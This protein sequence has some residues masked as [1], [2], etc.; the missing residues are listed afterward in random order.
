MTDAALI[1]LRDLIGNI[2]QLRGECRQLGIH[3]AG[4]STSAE[5]SNGASP[6]QPNPKTSSP[7]G[8]PR[9]N[10]PK[11]L[12][13]GARSPMR[14]PTPGSLRA[15]IHAILSRKG[16]A[17]RRADIVAEVASQKGVE[18]DANLKAKIGDVLTN[19]HDPYFKKISY[20]VYA[21]AKSI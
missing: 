8:L 11:D 14:C 18:P 2:L 5:S 3:S 19:Q 21:I 16:G 6:K 12:V 13:E 20:G 15:V 9:C 10:I 7:I 1:R 4:R 17:M